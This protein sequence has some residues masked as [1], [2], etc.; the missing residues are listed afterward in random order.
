MYLFA[1]LFNGSSPD[2]SFLTL[3]E[4]CPYSIFNDPPF[5]PNIDKISI[6]VLGFDSVDGRVSPEPEF[7]NFSPGTDF[8]ACVSLTVIDDDDFENSEMFLLSIYATGPDFY[9]PFTDDL[10]F[11]VIT[12]ND[13]EGESIC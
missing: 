10:N 4:G 12:I 11:T 6:T 1:D 5:P 2:I 7:A 9:L 8:T 3:P 13:P